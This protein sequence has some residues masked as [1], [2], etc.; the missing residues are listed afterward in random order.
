[1]EEKEKESLEV[2]MGFSF[3]SLI[4]QR[5]NA[6]EDRDLSAPLPLDF[7]AAPHTCLSCWPGV[8]IVNSLDWILTVLKTQLYF[9][10]YSF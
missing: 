2:L 5:Q 3:A 8:S 7:V 4:V 10:L 6:D 9:L 1:M